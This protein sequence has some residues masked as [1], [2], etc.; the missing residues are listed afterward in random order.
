MQKNAETGAEH[1]VHLAELA[2]ERDH[3]IAA[4]RL[5]LETAKAELSAHRAE[6]LD[7]LT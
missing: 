5:D 2:A 4:V 3:A 7:A 1:E 6:Q